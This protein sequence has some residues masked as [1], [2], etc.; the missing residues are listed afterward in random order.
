[1]I[2]IA[3]THDHH[4]GSNRVPT[5]PSTRATVECA[6]VFTTAGHLTLTTRHPIQGNKLGKGVPVNAQEILEQVVEG[7][8]QANRTIDAMCEDRNQKAP[9]LLPDTILLDNS[10][11]LMWY[12]KA[13]NRMMWFHVGNKLQVRVW[14]PAVLFILDRKTKRLDVFA[15]ARSTRPTMNTKIYRAPFM[16]IS[17]TGDFCLGGAVLPKDLSATNIAAMEACLYDSNFTHLNDHDKSHAIFSDDN[18]HLRFWREQQK[19]NAKVKVSQL[20]F[21]CRI[22]DLQLG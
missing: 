8:A 15:L 17:R 21:I 2:N 3:T 5:V 4:Y 9:Q 14:W 1:M 13:Q 11:T 20:P 6:I 10:K 22:S 7:N 19:S 12:A 16:N 18:S